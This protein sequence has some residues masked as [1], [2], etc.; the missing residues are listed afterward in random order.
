MVPAV[1][2][3]LDELPLNVNG[4]LDRRALPAPEFGGGGVYVAPRTELER[5]VA[6]IWAGVLGVERVGVED[7]FF[8][9]GG[10]SILSVQVTSRVRAALGVEVP[11]RVLFTHPTVAGLVGV[12]AADVGAGDVDAVSVIPV[13]SR[14]GE[15]PLSFAQQRLWFLNEFA[16]DSS[17]Y[18][19]P[20]AWRL[21]GELDVAALAR[22]LSALVARHESL[23]TTFESVDGHGVQVV[24]PPGE[25]QLAVVDLAGR[26]EADRQVEVDRVVAQ[27]ALRPFD[28]TQGP[29]LRVGLLRLAAKDHVLTV[30]CHH[31]ITDGWS[32][33][34]LLG[35]LAELYRAESTGTAA[36]LPVLAVQY[37]DFAVWQRQRVSGAVAEQQ[38]GYWRHQLDGVAAL[39]LPTDRPRPAVHTTRGA[40]VDF[41]VAPELTAGLKQLGRGRDTT[42]FMTLVAACQVLFARWSGQDDVAVGTVTSGRDR[43]ELEGLIGF[44]VNTVVLRS[45]VDRG[46]SFRELLAEVKNTVLDAF[47]HQDVPFERLVDELAPARDISRTPLFQA[48]V[49][50]QNTPNQAGGL[51]GLDIDNVAL[52]TVNASFDI[53]V[54]FEEFDGG[55]YATLTYN[56]DLFD[57]ATIKRMAQHL[58]VLFEG[59]VAQPDQLVSDLPIL[60]PAET[61]Q[62][63]VQWNGTAEPTAGA[64]LPELFQAQATRTPQTTAVSCAGAG[65]SYAELNTRA[66]Q[67]ARHLIEHGA[68]PERFVALALPR[69]VEMIVAIV[70]VLKSG[71]A[72][73]PIDLSHPPERI[74]AMLTDAAPVAIL[75]NTETTSG[76][77]ELGTTPPRIVLDDPDVT[78][79]INTQPATDLTDADRE[80]PLRPDS[81]AYV[82]YTSGSTGT[83]KGVVIPHGNVTRLFSA[84]QHWFGFD[85][86]GHCILFRVCQ[87]SS[88][89][90]A[91]SPLARTS[92]ASRGRGS[93]TSS[94]RCTRP[95]RGLNTTTRSER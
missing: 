92:S 76:L 80:S 35:D 39:E 58:Q 30:V 74:A 65:L 6:D 15:L 67:L 20:W 33:G 54:H 95:G 29:L 79:R 18:I 8:E 66:N 14:A 89:K 50:L 86:R 62:V 68:R 55:L 48:M 94:T 56:T 78:T 57:T 88:T 27:E 46:Q 34:V 77:P 53:S 4:K 1:F 22:A 23:R 3:V 7:S 44:F 73:L 5:V 91:N 11:L 31:I 59:I 16:P 25:V 60:T 85:E 26:S 19:T 81:P 70:A 43:A 45:R 42:L 63:L 9:L 61:Q 2:V 24:H 32:T 12:I 51:L 83:P 36:E 84:T 10:D 69:S 71:A 49:V 52:P 21:R 72:Y 40:L 38:L 13:V 64:T 93:G 41:V 28:L 47:A 87:S 37:A 75:T 90:R 82:I 17:E